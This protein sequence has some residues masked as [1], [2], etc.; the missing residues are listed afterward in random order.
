MW[1]PKDFALGLGFMGFGG[2]DSGCGA[3]TVKV[4]VILNNS[5]NNNSK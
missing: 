2:L 4:R 3:F 5:I 1:S